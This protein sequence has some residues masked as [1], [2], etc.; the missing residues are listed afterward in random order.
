MASFSSKEKQAHNVMKQLSNHI[1]SCG[2]NRNVK[3]ALTNIADWAIYSRVKGLKDITKEQAID[4]LS[5]RAEEV[6]QSTL[7]IERQSLEKMMQKVTKKLDFNEKLPIIK[8]ELDTIIDC[9][10]YTLEQAAA[11][12]N[13]QKGSNSLATLITIDAGL[14]SH[15]L[16][17]LTP[18]GEAILSDRPYRKDLFLGRN[19]D[20]YT[21]YAVTGKGGLVRAVS[22][23]N[24]LSHLLEE[25]KLEY[26][27]EIV[28]RAINYTTN[29]EIGGG[30]NWS[31]SFNQMSIKVCGFTNGGHG[32]RHSYAQ[33]RMKVLMKLSDTSFED[34]LEIVSQELGHFRPEITWVYLRAKS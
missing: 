9:R 32:L 33:N 20:E 18:I 25:V 8:S 23:Q 29:Y 30:I 5:M 13:R 31:S 7:D 21:L 10:A 34:C 6:Q 16:F 4:Y 27:K 24:E 14:R 12:A 28:D 3:A 22:I 17:T 15:E 26:P 11:I 19:P 2:S 1:V